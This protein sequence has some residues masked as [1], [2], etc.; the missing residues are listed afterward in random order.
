MKMA[1]YKMQNEPALFILTF[2]L[3][4]LQFSFADA[5]NKAPAALQG[6]GIDQKLNSQLPLD[7]PFRDENGK[8]VRLGD[9]LN[10]KPAILTLVYYECPMLCTQVL[11]GLTGS[12]RVLSF[13]AGKEFNIITVSFD[14]GETPALAGG[15]K[16]A[17]LK[18]YGR[19]GAEIGWHF[20]TGDQKSIAR[21]TSAVGFKYNYDPSVDQFAHASAIMVLTPEGKLSR[22]FYGI[23]YSI[24]DL[25]L[26]LVEA[27]QNKIGSL[28]DQFLLYCF[29]YDPSTGKYSAF[30]VNLIRLG[31]IATVLSLS[32]FI[33]A[34]KRR[35]RAL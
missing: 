5:Q 31:G 22:Y 7:A 19:P 14:P 26:A 34:M 15:K 16:R 8:I 13:S 9:L 35:E 21:L 6:V 10:G 27:S 2:A 25:R 1:K 23:E 11:N 32:I 17:Y 4:I 18:E 28:A 20:L 24:R 30:A 3:C 33:V 29:H 12:L